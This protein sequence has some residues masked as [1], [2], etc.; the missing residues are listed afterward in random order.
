MKKLLSI[1]LSVLMVFSMVVPA[2]AVETEKEIVPIIYIRGNGQKIV[3]A[4]KKEVVCDVADF[5]LGGDGD[6]TKNKV[7]EAA[8][9]IL[10]PFLTEGLLSDNWDNYGKAIYD[11]LSP[12]F[13]EAAL[14]GNGDPQYGTHLDP[15][16]QKYNDRTQEELAAAFKNQNFYTYGFYFDWRLSPYDIV[17][18]LHNF[19]TRVKT[20]TGANAVSLTSRCLGGSVLNAYLD[21]YGAE[22]IKNVLYCDTL[23]NG[24]T[25]ISKGFSGQIEFDAKSIQRY[26]EE[27]EYLAEI[28]YDTGLN[29]TGIAG[30]IVEKSLDLFTQVGVVDKLTG[31]IEELYGRLYKALIPALLKATGVASQPIYWTFVEEDD[32]DRALNVMFG[33][34]GS[35]EWEAN[36]GLIEKICRYRDSISSKHDEFVLGFSDKIHFGVIA[37]YGLMTAPVTKGYDELSDTLVSLKQ[38]SLGATCAP[39]GSVLSDDEI[40]EGSIEKGYLSPDKQVDVS[41]CLFPETTWIIKNVHHDDFDKTCK[42]LAEKFLK[43]TN[44]TVENSGY[45]RFRINDYKT[46]TVSDMTEDNCADI[47][48]I[49]KPEEEPTTASRLASLIRFLTV[50]IDVLV[51]LFN[52]ELD[53]SNLF[54]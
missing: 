38:S 44:V 45:S 41:T 8:V 6:E 2:C 19:I 3:N 15:E 46:G 9:N 29:I 54:A 4:E 47:D 35:E 20:A 27:L 39:I 24:C 53:F 22:G 1:V 31:G 10:L 48:F 23:S 12:L 16:L 18:D 52:G 28:G 7:I 40:A 50:V 34:E 13:K 17:E 49:S 11:E 25:L 42:A 37:K 30:E 14:D 26:E 32:F 43:G 5:S 51:K 36:A 21:T 33:E